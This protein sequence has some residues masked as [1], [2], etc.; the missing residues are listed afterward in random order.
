MHS[1]VEAGYAKKSAS[2]GLGDE[3]HQH[4]AAPESVTIRTAS[5]LSRMGMAIN[6]VMMGLERDGN[7][8]TGRRNRDCG[9][10][11]R[12]S[13]YRRGRLLLR[14]QHVVDDVDHA[15]RCFTLAMVTVATPPFSSVQHDLAPSITATSSRL[16]VSMARRPRRP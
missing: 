9:R 11:P 8:L 4:D 7:K 2:V 13:C 5:P 16:T 12:A 15:V 6:R 1:Q 14:Q 3:A 10:P